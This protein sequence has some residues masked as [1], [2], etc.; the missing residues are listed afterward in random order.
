METPKTTLYVEWTDLN[1]PYTLENSIKASL[2]GTVMRRIYFD[3]IR[4]EA[5][6][7]YSVV[8][9][10]QNNKAGDKP[11]TALT[12]YAPLKPECTDLALKI[13]D[14][15]MAKACEAIDPVKLEDAKT[16]IL[17]NHETQLKE[18]GYWYNIISAYANDGLDFYSGFEDI[19]KAQ[20]PE[21][22]A[23]FARQ[24]VAAGNKLEVVMTPAE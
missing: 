1:M 9:Y 19:V 5:S 24:L 16:A 13:V 22:I 23:A 10:A 18:N 8:A 12:V 2:L 17:K 15:E 7:A 14:E 21:T 6:A 3:K 11:Y 20:T 4:E